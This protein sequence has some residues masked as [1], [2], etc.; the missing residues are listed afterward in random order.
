MI[1]S[2]LN[3]IGAHSESTAMVGDRM[4]TDVVAGI[5]AGLTTYLVLTGSTS[6]DELTEFAYRPDDVVESVAEL[7]E[8]I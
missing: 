2:G 3:R 4:D 6:R 1:R 8:T 5:E 7:V